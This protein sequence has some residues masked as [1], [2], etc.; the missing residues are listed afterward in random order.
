MASTSP[1]QTPQADSAQEAIPQLS[2]EI[3]T[4]SSEHSSLLEERA[5]DVDEGDDSNKL[6]MESLVNPPLPDEL[7]EAECAILRGD[8]IGSTTYTHRWVLHTLLTITEALPKYLTTGDRYLKIDHKTTSAD[9]E[10]NAEHTEKQ[11]SSLSTSSVLELEEDV[12]NAACQLWDMT[13]EPDVVSHLL[14]LDVVDILQL[15]KEIITLS[16]AP[17]LTVSKYN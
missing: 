17:R 3:C 15:A 6:V 5:T 11:H 4:D 10:A 9:E 7:E 12:E 13:A 2:P 1:E 16:R 14:N 8:A